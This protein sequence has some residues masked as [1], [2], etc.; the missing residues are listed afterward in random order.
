MPLAL[1]ASSNSG[2]PGKRSCGGIAAKPAVLKP[3]PSA[4]PRASSSVSRATTASFTRSVS[5]AR[6]S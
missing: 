4:K 6:Q 1:F 3:W 5:K 2:T